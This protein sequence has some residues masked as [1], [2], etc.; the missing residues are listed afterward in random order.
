MFTKVYADPFGEASVSQTSF[1]LKAHH[2]Y[3]DCVW[4]WCDIH[5][6][7]VLDLSISPLFETAEQFS[8][9]GCDNAKRII[10]NVTTRNRHAA[11]Q[12]CSHGSSQADASFCFTCSC[13]DPRGPLEC[14]ILAPRYALPGGATHMFSR[15][16]P[17]TFHGVSLH[18]EEFKTMPMSHFRPLSRVP[19]HSG[20]F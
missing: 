17:G 3:C 11:E 10:Q 20:T 6:D 13:H 4:C 1:H 16:D 9:N 15:V 8:S 14:R 19:I 7:V 12:F 18:V 5:T 2:T